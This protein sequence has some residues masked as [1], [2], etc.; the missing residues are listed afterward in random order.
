MKKKNC[1]VIFELA[2]N[3]MGDLG[4]AKKIINQYYKISSEYKKF[5]IDFAFKFQFRN[6]ETFIHKAYKNSNHEG[7][8][9][10]ETTELNDT[11]WKNLIKFTK[12]KFI[13][14]CTA[15]DEIS[16]D[17]VIKNNFDYIKIASCSINDW[18]LIEYLSKKVKSKIIASLGGKNEDEIREIVSFFNNRKKKI[19]YLYCVAKYPTNPENL[20][21]EYFLNLKSLY[22]EKIAGFSTHEVPG[23]TLSGAIAYSMG[24]RIFEKHVNIKSNKYKINKYSTTPDQIKLWLENLKETILRYGSS[25][26]RN[27]FLTEEKVNLLQFQRGVYVREKMTIEEG[28]ELDYKKIS[29]KF[30]SLK[31]QLTANQ[32]SKFK[33]FV[34]KKNFTSNQPIFLKDLIVVDKRKDVFLIKE[35]IK[36]LI[37]A[38]KIILPLNPRIEISHHEGLKKFYKTGLSMIT[39]FNGN[40][41]KKLLFLLKNQN[42]PPQYHRIK[43]E[44][45]FVIYGS[46]KIKLTKKRKTISKILRPGEILTIEPGTIHEFKAIGKTG[47]VIEELSTMHIKADSYYLSKKITN[48]KNR[49]SFISLY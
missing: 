11:E 27:I 29:F 19:Q 12:K 38:S 32:Y 46:V 30:P 40:Y 25:K 24:A 1:L 43:S 42:H 44:T 10:F 4:Y 36:Q 31:G 39:V 8:K 7:V 6:L 21:L 2:N 48:N 15:F 22:G 28:K 3:H 37:D 49:K 18:P 26:S 9:R 16:V 33:E 41:C 45:F 23:E 17:K 34:T 47:A 5:G 35:K 14:V 13:T 20:N